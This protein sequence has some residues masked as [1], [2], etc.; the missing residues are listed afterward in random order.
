[1]VEEEGDGV[2]W[3]RWRMWALSETAAV[4]SLAKS[5]RILIGDPSL[6]A[7][8]DARAELWG[9]LPGR[10]LE[11]QL[12]TGVSGGGCHRQAVVSPSSCSAR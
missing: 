12:S 3:W 4:A 6:R 8:R 2:L 5:T 10:C 1:M 9:G 11:R 7:R